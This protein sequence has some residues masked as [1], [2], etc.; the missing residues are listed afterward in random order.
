MKRI[1]KGFTLIE[2]MIV[3]AIIGILAAV[4]IPAYQNYIIKSKLASVA[5]SMDPIKLALGM[6]YQTNGAF[7]TAVFTVTSANAG[8]VTPTGGT[9]SFFSLG[10][11]SYP[12]LPTNLSKIGLDGSAQ[13]TATLTVTFTGILANSIDGNTLVMNGA[14]GA[15]S[16]NWSNTCTSIASTVT[17]VH[18][19]YNC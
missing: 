18:S 3:V 19:Y 14:P 4:A 13:T 5:T 12:T 15:T 17:A 16:M 2:L 9:D 1:Q 7:P 8:T 11:Q 10:L 6:Y